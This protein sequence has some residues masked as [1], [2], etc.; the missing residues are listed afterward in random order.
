MT[1]TTLAASFSKKGL[2][3]QHTDVSA[4][5]P[6]MGAA[7]QASAQISQEGRYPTKG[8]FTHRQLRRRMQKPKRFRALLQEVRRSG[9]EHPRGLLDLHTGKPEKILSRKALSTEVL[10]AELRW[11]AR[12]TPA[13]RAVRNILRI[14]LEERNIKPTPGHYEALILGQCHPEFGSI[15]NVKTILQEMEREGLPL[16]APIL[17]AALTVLSI[18]PD[19]HLRNNILDRLTQQQFALPNR[20]AHL[21]ILAL[22][23]EEQLEMATVELEKLSQKNQGSPIPSWLWTIYIH[24]I[25]DL[26]Q[27]F[28]A[29]IQLLY[30][31]S[32][33][34]FLFPRPTLLH[35]LLKASQAGDIH[36][37]KFVWHGYVES[38]HIIPNEELCMS[39][40][41]VA[42]KENDLKLAESVAVVL[43]SVAGNDMTDP[44]ALEY[45]GWEPARESPNLLGVGDIQVNARS[46]SEDSSNT[47][48]D[49]DAVPPPRPT[50][51]TDSATADSELST[52]FSTPPL[53]PNPA[54]PP[55]PPRPLPR[56]ALALLSSLGLTD[57][58]AGAGCTGRRRR[59]PAR[60]IL[61]P[62]FREEMGLAG[63]RFDP[64]LALLRG[65]DWRKK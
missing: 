26:R 42:A 19:T 31:L 29:L 52:V 17:L 41:R 24:A 12:N 22:I 63:A 14:L 32:D 11:V 6:S 7:S 16:E 60:G 56:E 47:S 62:L 55:P 18:H 51:E 59:K 25:C 65:W 39:V 46:E 43:E 45:H 58:S 4:E 34:G 3:S 36:V 54:L 27:D 1:G 38:M 61:Y 21:N 40:L 50:S 30:R 53:L 48:N 13:P 49:T 37:T 35:L 5:A 44:P 20:H 64:R 9:E 23:R 28:D 57:F 2:E 8:G 10:E 15:E 33:S